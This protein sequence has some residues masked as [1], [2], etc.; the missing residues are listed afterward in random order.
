MADKLTCPSCKAVISADGETVITR[1]PR[2]K[3]MDDLEEELR[4]TRKRIEAVEKK[5]AESGSKKSD[6]EW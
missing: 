1:S 2:I 5:G 3:R 6:D 4:D